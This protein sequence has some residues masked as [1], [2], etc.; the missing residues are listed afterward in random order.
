[1]LKK[2][3]LLSVS[4]FFV[5]FIGLSDYGYGCHKNNLTHGK[6]PGP[7][8]PPDGG[9]GSGG[10]G[11]RSIPVSVTFL[12]REGDRIMSDGFAY[13]DGEEEVT[14]II[15]KTGDLHLFLTRGGR[16]QTPM[17]TLHYD[18]SDCVTPPCIEDTE[19]LF[20]LQLETPGAANMFTRGIDLIEEI[21]AGNSR[22][23]LRVSM[24]INLTNLNGIDLGGW[25]VVF[26][27]DDADCEGSDNI[28]ITR[29]ISGN[30]WEI[31]A[32]PTDYACLKRTTGGGSFEFN[33]LYRMPFKIRVELLSP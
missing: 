25:R 19:P 27:D 26:N 10:G 15:R 11:G 28:S 12:N 30:E 13:I 32:G 33:G 5:L 9:D 4:I 29:A 20:P 7:C 16:F 2:S 6:N 8:D 14:A 24:A 1:M 3:T 18:F 17:R 22:G 21:E 23:D 31:E